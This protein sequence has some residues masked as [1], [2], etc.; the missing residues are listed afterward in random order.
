MGGGGGEY[1][2]KETERQKR[3][4]KGNKKLSRNGTGKVLVVK[5]VSVVVYVR[6]GSVYSILSQDISGIRVCRHNTSC[7]FTNFLHFTT[8]LYF[9]YNSTGLS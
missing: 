6:C 4:L 3:N 2:N 1:Y 7:N 5:H 8:L 9:T